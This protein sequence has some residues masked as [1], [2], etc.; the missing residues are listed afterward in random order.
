[1]ILE[2]TESLANRSSISPT[3]TLGTTN[4][5]KLTDEQKAVATNKGW[6]LT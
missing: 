3:L 4:L 6:S 5:N 1:M 2:Q